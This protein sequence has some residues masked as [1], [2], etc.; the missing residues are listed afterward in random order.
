MCLGRICKCCLL[1]V[2]T[3]LILLYAGLSQS[4]TMKELGYN[5]TN[6]SIPNLY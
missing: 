6:Y 3:S 1:S 4:E 2:L 5:V